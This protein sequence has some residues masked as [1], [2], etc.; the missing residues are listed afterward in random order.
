M[1]NVLIVIPAIKKRAVIP[2]QL[3]KK[4]DGITLIQRAINTVLELTSDRGKILI[5]TDS[6]EISLIAKRNNINYKKDESLSLD[7]EN[8]VQEV[9]DRIK[10]FSQKHIILYRANTP[11]LGVDTLKSAYSKFLKLN[12]SLLVSV[13]QEERS[14][15]LIDDNKLKK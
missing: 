6:D 9:V 5:I 8:I 15:Y 3:V 1:D 11:L 2:D 4:M 13:K 10:E 12:N 14:V 7:S